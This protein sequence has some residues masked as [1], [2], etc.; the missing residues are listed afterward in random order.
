MQLQDPFSM[1][2]RIFIRDEQSGPIFIGRS[3]VQEML[4]NDSNDDEYELSILK[5][6]VNEDAL[7]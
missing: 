4:E 6:D 2:N 1:P 3:V 5:Y 7:V